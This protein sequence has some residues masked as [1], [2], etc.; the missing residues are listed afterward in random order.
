MKIK[1]TWMCARHV[2]TASPF[3]WISYAFSLGD[4]FPG[5]DPRRYIPMGQAPLGAR[6]QPMWEEGPTVYI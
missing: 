4:E 1:I 6:I 5:Y 3:S 2:T